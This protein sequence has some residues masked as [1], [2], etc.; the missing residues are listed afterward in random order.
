MDHAPDA[1]VR[2]GL[3]E[4]PGGVHVHRPILRV[5]HA[6]A[7]E[8]RGEMVDDVDALERPA[9][10]RLVAHVARHDLDAGGRQRPG[11]RG[12]P[13]QAAHPVPS[14]GQAPGQREPGE[15]AR[16]RDEHAWQHL[17]RGRLRHR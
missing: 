16:A 9:H 8:Y 1:R 11:A 14:R 5:G 3:D 10:E 6:G 13:G 7:A 2:R 4:L 17:L 12:V 15:P